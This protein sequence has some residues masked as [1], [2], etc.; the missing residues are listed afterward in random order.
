[1]C[2]TRSQQ[3]KQQQKTCDAIR[4]L[5]LFIN[6]L[7]SSSSGCLKVWI[8]TVG[9]GQSEEKKKEIVGGNR[10]FNMGYNHILYELISIL[11]LKIYGVQ[12]CTKY[13]ADTKNR[14][15]YT[16]E[17]K[18]FMRLWFISFDL[19]G[20]P[21]KLNEIDTVGCGMRRCSPK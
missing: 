4:F 11:M 21:V 17:K 5:F 2:C 1:M 18:S 19:F 6:F 16:L 10:M 3:Q 8:K 20:T 14:D 13:F 12:S 15:A 7:A 9:C